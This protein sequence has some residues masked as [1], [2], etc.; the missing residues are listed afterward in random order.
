MELTKNACTTFNFIYKAFNKTIRISIE[1]FFSNI[2]KYLL[3]D[4]RLNFLTNRN[5]DI[6]FEL[7]SGRVC[8]FSKKL[9]EKRVKRKLKIYESSSNWT[10]VAF[11][12]GWDN[13]CQFQFI[14]EKNV[15][16]KIDNLRQHSITI[17][18]RN[19]HFGPRQFLSPQI[20]IILEYF[21]L[22]RRVKLISHEKEETTKL[23]IF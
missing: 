7:F 2:W 13:N 15:N 20:L 6:T 21:L 23:A 17:Q 19:W 9:K 11:L 4:F 12:E 18:V 5:Y 3:I 22:N 8:F 14:S 16:F 10:P 1:A